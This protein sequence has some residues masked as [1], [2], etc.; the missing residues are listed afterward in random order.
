MASRQK[1]ITLKYSKERVIISD[2]LPFELPIIFTNRYFHSFLLENKIETRSNTIS[3]LSNGR[4]LDQLVC[5]IFGLQNELTHI[6]TKK[7][8]VGT[9]KRQFKEYELKR[10]KATKPF[11]YN[12]SHKEDEFRSLSVPHPRNQIGMV[13]FYDTCKET[14]IYYC[15][16]SNFSIRR[17]AKVAR[18]K[19]IKNRVLY[20]DFANSEERRDPKA[21]YES[22]RSFFSYKYYSNIHKFYESYQF[23]RCEKKYNCLFKLDISR[24]F[25]SIYTH[26]LPWAIFGKDNTKAHMSANSLSFAN[27][28]DKLM[29]SANYGETNGIIIGP[30][31]SRIF[32]EILL[33]SIDSHVENELSNEHSLKHKVDY[34]IF[35]YVDDYF[36]F[37]ND[38]SDKKKITKTLQHSLGMYKLHLNSSKAITYTKPIIT[39]I[40]MA[41]QKI[42]EL[43]NK[44]IAYVA[45]KYSKK[46]EE[47]F[48]PV[49]SDFLITQF[50]VIIKSYNVEYKE[51]LNYSLAIVEKRCEEVLKECSE[52]NFDVKLRSGMVSFIIAILEFVYFVYSVSPKVNTTIRLCRLIIMFTS[53]YRSTAARDDRKHLVFK[54]IYDNSCF[55]LR[56]FK[57]SKHT[58]IETL[59]LL[60]ALSELGRNY[61]LDQSVLASYVGISIE[62]ESY[63]GGESINYLSYTVL[64]FY[65]K[66]K[67]RYRG[68]KKHIE[69]QI[70]EFVDRERQSQLAH[71][72][73]H[74]LLLLDCLSSPYVSRKTKSVLLQK[75]NIK[76]SKIQSQIINFKNKSGK[77]QYWF[78][79]WEKLDFGRELDTKQGQE[80]Y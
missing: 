28:F 27:K 52:T 50:K 13:E 3:W 19:I 10:P 15:S 30:E 17:P 29:Q 74:T 56:K 60:I 32:A 46:N 48:T 70:V 67:K 34:E 57:S 20:Q 2:V 22:A 78:T 41:K 77:K 1:R 79:T 21:G 23:H 36:V 9:T 39:D 37:Y 64:L 49:K 42:A 54:C 72:T 24:C 55:I 43:L 68:L 75:R 80:V 76:H 8:Y 16:K 14:I 5:L 53:F 25:D 47:E 69:A 51:M 31:V 35:R 65:M 45:R 6:S 40:S 18:Y 58:Q 12:I 61:W 66:N 71:S 63:S 73:E 59:Y 44:E 38:E 7:R 4:A 11:V 33:Q 62:N 26:T